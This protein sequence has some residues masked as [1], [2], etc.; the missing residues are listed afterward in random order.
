VSFLPTHSACTVSRALFNLFGFTLSEAKMFT[1]GK[2]HSLSSPSTS[3]SVHSKYIFYRTS[4]A[5]SVLELAS[6]SSL[7]PASFSVFPLATIQK[8]Y[9]SPQGFPVQCTPKLY[10]I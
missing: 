2:H 3:I 4:H 8:K 10:H 9:S 7:E 6:L 5:V 1:Q